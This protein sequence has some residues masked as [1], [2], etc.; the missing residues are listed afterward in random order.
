MVSHCPVVAV[1]FRSS[2][3]CGSATPTTISDRKATNAEKT[4]TEI[5]RTSPG[6]NR[7]VGSGLV[8]AGNTTIHLKAFEIRLT[9]EYKYPNRQWSQVRTVR[10][11]FKY[12][13]NLF[14]AAQDFPAIGYT[15]IGK[16]FKMIGMEAKPTI[17]GAP[18]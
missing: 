13:S 6:D 7:L 10:P 12:V 11:G 17:F 9:A 18:E 14:E 15:G 1:M 8:V 5:V 4:R 3:I 16:H 2:M